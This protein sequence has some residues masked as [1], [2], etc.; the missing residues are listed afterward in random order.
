MNTIVFIIILLLRKPIDADCFDLTKEIEPS[1]KAPKFKVVDR[2][3]NIKY[4]NISV[5]FALK[6][7]REEHLLSM[8]R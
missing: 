1:Y 4:G 6:I 3:R 7:V 5:K 8:M 2:A